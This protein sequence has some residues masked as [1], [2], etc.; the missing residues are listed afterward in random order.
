MFLLNLVIA[1]LAVG[2][3]LAIHG[4]RFG[5]GL[6]AIHDA[7]DAA[8]V[9]GVPTFRYKMVA[10]VLGGVLGGIERRIVRDVDGY[11][12]VESVFTLDFPLLVILICV[13]GGR[14]HWL[15]PVIGAVF[16]VVLQ[17]RLVVG[18]L[19]S[20][21]D[22]ILG[23]LLAGLVV[24]APDGPVRAAA[25]PPVA[26]RS[27]VVPGRLYRRCCSAATTPI[28]TRC[29]TACWPRPWWRRWWP[30][31][32]RPA[33]ADSLAA[34]RRPGRCP[35][36]RPAVPLQLCRRPPRR[37]EVAAEPGGCWCPCAA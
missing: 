22:I 35:P 13:L 30:A 15:G 21:R 28:W 32:F 5:R 18:G 16:L 20:W 2:V 14:R 7:E 4:S 19:A 24:L 6:A 9:L 12:V 37:P 1:T 25:G 10:I 33:S 34:G 11:V 8:E 31:A 26:A 3:A 27:A 29:S 36:I 23:A 17:D